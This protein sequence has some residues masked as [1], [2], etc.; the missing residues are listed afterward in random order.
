M[1]SSSEG[2][3]GDNVTRTATDT[4]AGLSEADVSSNR[5]GVIQQMSKNIHTVINI[6]QYE[7]VY[8]N[9]GAVWRIVLGSLRFQWV[10][11]VSC[12]LQ[13]P[14]NPCIRARTY[15]LLRL[16]WARANIYV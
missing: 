13:E 9:V 2:L 6:K 8:E 5:S 4:W 12:L 3:D 1:C 10:R 7:S 11:C 15:V 16:L 14:L